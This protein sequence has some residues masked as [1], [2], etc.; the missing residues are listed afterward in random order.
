MRTMKK[1][2]FALSVLSL[3]AVPAFAQNNAAQL[4][5][6]KKL[7]QR[8]FDIGMSDPSVLSPKYA[9]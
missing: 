6:N 7:A 8:F 4:E 3:A 1:V 9:S 5:S 2:V